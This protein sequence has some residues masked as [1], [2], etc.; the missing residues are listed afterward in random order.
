MQQLSSEKAQWNYSKWKRWP[1]SAK[2]KE[3]NKQKK[4]LTES[5]D[6][7][8]PLF[9][10]WTQQARQCLCVKRA[11]LNLECLLKCSKLTR[12]KICDWQNS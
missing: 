12:D 1:N 11:F 6:K 4:R 5:T 3:T 2:K 9:G 10:F 8:Q 7:I